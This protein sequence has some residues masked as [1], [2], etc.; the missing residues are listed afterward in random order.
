[1][2]D[3]I[4]KYCKQSKIREK[5][6]TGNS[7]QKNTSVNSQVTTTNPTEDNS[8][9]C[10]SSDPRILLF[11]ISDSSVDIVRVDDKGSKPQFVSVQ[12]QGL[13]TSDIIDIGVD[14]TITGL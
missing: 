7:S 6:S 12:V 4:T 13:P 9:E 14:I 11:F 1:M 10:D 2:S 5:E 8:D 3:H